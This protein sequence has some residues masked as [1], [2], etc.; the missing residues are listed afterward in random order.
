MVTRGKLNETFRAKLTYFCL[1]RTKQAETVSFFYQDSCDIF[2]LFGKGVIL[3]ARQVQKIT[4][5]CVLCWR[6]KQADRHAKWRCHMLLVVN[7]SCVFLCTT[8]VSNCIL[9]VA[10]TRQETK[11]SHTCVT[12]AY[13]LCLPLLY[14]I[15]GPNSKYFSNQTF[16]WGKYFPRLG[17]TCFLYTL[18]VNMQI[19]CK[20]CLWSFPGPDA[21]IS[22]FW[23]K[24]F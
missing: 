17:L 21:D 20:I 1:K 3:G 22:F 13:I 10:R 8:L 14:K 4:Q 9:G 6:I 18:I 15:F 5:F 16:S 11:L 7:N 23:A 19:E 24:K 2:H 12:N